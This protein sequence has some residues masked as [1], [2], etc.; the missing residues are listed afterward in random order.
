[1]EM[2]DTME[3]RSAEFSVK[4]WLFT[5]CSKPPK[6]PKLDQYATKGHR[7][8]SILKLLAQARSLSCR[9]S[10]ALGILKVAR[11]AEANKRACACTEKNG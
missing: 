10:E 7:G 11:L 4:L 8:F 3:Q 6:K 9:L 1:M 5:G 2:S